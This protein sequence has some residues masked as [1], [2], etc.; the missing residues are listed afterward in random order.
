VRTEI[1]DATAR[2]LDGARLHEISVESISKEAG[3]S[4]PTFYSYFASKLEIVLELYQLAAAE[5][6]SA[7]TP[8]WARPEDQ[9]PPDGI[10]QGIRALAD[11]WMPR[12]AVF[13]AAVELRYVDPEMMATSER[14]I[15][16]FA[17]NIGAQLEADRA[18]GIAPAGPPAGPL[19]TTLLWSSEHALYIASRGL[20]TDLPDEYAAIVPLETMWLGALY[21]TIPTPS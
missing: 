14:T 12:R 15:A 7:V 9:T 19:V 8:F 10:R 1:L 2:L 3:V 6:Y 11:A 21:G 20:S 5:M 18:A 16:H 13:Q 17:S 4:R